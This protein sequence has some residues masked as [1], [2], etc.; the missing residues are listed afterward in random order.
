MPSGHLGLLWRGKALGLRVQQL[1]Q[2]LGDPPTMIC[3]PDICLCVKNEINHR[4]FPPWAWGMGAGHTPGQGWA[5][6]AGAAGER[7]NIFTGG[8]GGT[9]GCC[10]A[11][12]GSWR[13]LGRSPDIGPN[14]SQLP[15]LLQVLFVGVFLIPHGHSHL[16]PSA[17][18]FAQ[19]PSQ[20]IFQA[21]NIREG[22]RLLLLPQESVSL[23]G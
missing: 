8:G 13:A 14:T 9:D 5:V 7:L 6:Q 22:R 12:V 23:C 2:P 19:H 18:S 21:H 11:V 10:L 17:H 15:Y 3:S 20:R 4:G 16:S 1:G